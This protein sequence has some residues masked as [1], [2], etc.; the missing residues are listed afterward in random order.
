MVRLIEVPE[1]KMNQFIVSE[2]NKV[3]KAY[4]IDGEIELSNLEPKMPGDYFFNIHAGDQYIGFISLTEYKYDNN[5]IEFDI[6]IFE[7]FRGNG[8]FTRAL[9]E[10][11]KWV[12]EKRYIYLDAVVYL[13]NESLEIMDKTL[14]NGG[15][16]STENS[17]VIIYRKS[18]NNE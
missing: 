4:K 15:F 18:L 14:T 13:E 7:E 3:P 11:E 10:L 6:L 9:L 5:V 17:D 8:Y 2:M 12:V 1:I 16:E